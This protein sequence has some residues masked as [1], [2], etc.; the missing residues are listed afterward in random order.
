MQALAT[1]GGTNSGD[2]AVTSLDVSPA[3]GMLVAGFYSGRVVLF[4]VSAVAAGKVAVLKASELHRAP[5]S[6]VRFVSATEPSVMSVR[7]RFCSPYLPSLPPP[8]SLPRTLPCYPPHPTAQVD[9]AGAVFFTA[10]AKT[11]MRWGAEPRCVL[12]G[13]T[14][15]PVTAVAVLLPTADAGSKGGGGDAGAKDVAG[16]SAVSFITAAFSA[17]GS[18]GPD[19][20]GSGS[21]PS[22]GTLV[23]LCTWDCTFIIATLPEVRVIHKWSRP[24]NLG[25]EDG[26]AP[27]RATPS[28][29]AIA[30][31]R[32][33]VCGS[34][35]LE[36]LEDRCA[37]AQLL[38]KQQQGTAD[39]API[40]DDDVA[41]AADSSAISVGGDE[42]LSQA[43]SIADDR[44]GATGR[45]AT[46][47]PPPAAALGGASAPRPP[48]T[49]LRRRVDSTLPPGTGV[50]TQ[51]P[52]PVLARAW[53]NRLQLLQVQ[54]AGGFPAE[55]TNIATE[56]VHRRFSPVLGP[57]LGVP[58]LVALQ[59]ANA[60]AA[61]A[62]VSTARAGA[63]ASAGASRVFGSLTSTLMNAGGVDTS[64]G[65]AKGP[66]A[67]LEF[68][69][70]DDLP[71]AD[72]I[73]A[74]AWVSDAAL[75]FM[76]RPDTAA[77]RTASSASSPAEGAAPSLVLLETDT[78]E[79]C[80]LTGRLDP[81]PTP[82]L[83]RRKPTLPSSLVLASVTHL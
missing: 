16:V 65:G 20:G 50:V 46:G 57:S 37:A 13:T 1:A 10:F 17:S 63:G 8:T 32:A 61:A 36:A 7:G 4:D 81:A 5:V 21:S 60:Q 9:T 75:V 71:T 79:V 69:L 66:S 41:S 42:H 44:G 52:V 82:P 58:A 38:Q 72:P 80:K 74:V 19:S 27:S 15:G 24:A 64:A 3:L 56:A 29:P 40:G 18:A 25:G 31:G 73:A 53:G 26:H 49:V 54:P 83:L 34:A 2:G 77:S 59:Q 48:P 23:A 22:F 55:H 12:D 28:V 35:V 14:A 43:G 51:A 45:T 11:F 33:R 39:A 68:V 67:P 76:T 47:A 62:A 6:V 78:L 70:A 30:W